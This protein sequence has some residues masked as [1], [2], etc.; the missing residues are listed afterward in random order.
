MRERNGQNAEENASSHPESGTVCT[1]HC[2]PL[3]TNMDPLNTF[4]TLVV[5]RIHANLQEGSLFP[6]IMVRCYDT[7]PPL[8]GL[9]EVPTLQLVTPIRGRFNM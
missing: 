8:S 5:L 6:P 4:L 3:Q 1:N 7:Y 2:S 9:S